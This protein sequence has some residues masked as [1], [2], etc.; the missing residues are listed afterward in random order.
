LLYFSLNKEKSKPENIKPN[1]QSRS[2]VVDIKPQLA[3]HNKP[4]KNVANDKNVRETVLT[5]F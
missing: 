2:D 3:K 1:N 4:N 5:Q